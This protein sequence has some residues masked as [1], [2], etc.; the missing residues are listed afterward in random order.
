[1]NKP[2]AFIKEHGSSP[3]ASNMFHDVPA[4]SGFMMLRPALV[5]WWGVLCQLCHESRKPWDFLKWD[6]YRIKL[7]ILHNFHGIAREI[8]EHSP[9]LA[10]SICPATMP[11][12][13]LVC[14]S[15]STDQPWGMSEL[16]QATV[17]I[18]MGTP[19]QQIYRKASSWNKHP[20]WLW[21]F[22]KGYSRTG[23]KP[24]FQ[25]WQQALSKSKVSLN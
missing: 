14:P 24:T 9:S 25:R 10:P 21:P 22:P 6:F 2:Q 7:K 5:H 17:A 20:V 3:G 12:P 11:Q 23:G 8:H 13:V 16:K 1:M 19:H 4:L 15:L 18:P